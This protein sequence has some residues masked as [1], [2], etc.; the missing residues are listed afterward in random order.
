MF[1]PKQMVQLRVLLHPAQSHE[2]PAGLCRYL[3]RQQMY[4]DWPVDE[5]KQKV[6]WASFKWVLNLCCCVHSRV[7]LKPVSVRCI[8]YA[9]TVLAE[10]EQKTKFWRLIVASDELYIYTPNK[11][12]WFCSLS[13]AWRIWGNLSAVSM[14]KNSKYCFQCSYRH[15]YCTVIW[16]WNKMW[17]HPFTNKILRHGGFWTSYT[18]YQ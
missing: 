17:T 5:Q 4:L 14:D 18:S 15:E 12:H 16:T 10:L 13:L 7:Q 6:F 8:F 3:L 9:Y 1:C 2:C 11:V